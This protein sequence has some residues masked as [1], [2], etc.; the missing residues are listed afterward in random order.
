MATKTVHYYYLFF[1]IIIFFLK[2]KMLNCNTD[3]AIPAHKEK[4]VHERRQVGQ[5]GVQVLR[6][7]VAI[8]AQ[9]RHV[10][11]Q[12]VNGILEKQTVFTFGEKRK[13]TR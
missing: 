11:V 2:V 13:P 6:V 8:A 1:I 5:G 4:A 10:L 9:L 3:M 12:Q 7:Q